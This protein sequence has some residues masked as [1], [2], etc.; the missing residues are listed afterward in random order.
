MT[1]DDII[2]NITEALYMYDDEYNSDNED[3]QMCIRTYEEVG[4]L[5]TNSGFVIRV[6]DDEFQVTVVKR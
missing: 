1:E 2:D 6:G 5:T 4:M 3:N